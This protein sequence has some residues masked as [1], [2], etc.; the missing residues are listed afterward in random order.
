MRFTN[1]VYML[2][3]T[4]QNSTAVIAFEIHFGSDTEPSMYGTFPPEV[5]RKPF[6]IYKV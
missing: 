2:S 1:M 3:T 6:P 5:D 4:K